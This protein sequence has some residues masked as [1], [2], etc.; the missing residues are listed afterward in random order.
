MIEMKKMLTYPANLIHANSILE[1]CSPGFRRFQNLGEEVGD[2]IVYT[3][4]YQPI[5]PMT[6]WIIV[7]V[8]WDNDLLGGVY[9]LYGK[10]Y[11]QYA[12]PDGTRQ[13]NRLPFDVH[14]ALSKTLMDSDRIRDLS[15]SQVIGRLFQTLLSENAWKC[16]SEG[17]T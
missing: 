3:L 16:E 15:I 7:K 4:E 17:V 13:E 10:A 12:L 2:Q 9:Q 1:D 6:I 11:L 14:V 5:G 8:C